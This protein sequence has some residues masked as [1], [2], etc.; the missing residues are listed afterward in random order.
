M[1][2]IQPVL[3]CKLNVCV[4]DT[5]QW[6]RVK[7][8]QEVAV[9]VDNCVFVSKQQLLRLGLFNH[10]WVMLSRPG[11]SSRTCTGELDVKACMSRERLVSVVVVDLTL[12]SEFQIYD[13]VGVISATLWFNMTEGERISMKTCALRMKVL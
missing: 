8:Q 6:H 11:A 13:D 7:G 3:E 4:A 10:E 12:R 1:L 5:Q 2:D 9:D